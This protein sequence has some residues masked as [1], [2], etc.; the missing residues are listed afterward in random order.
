MDLKRTAGGAMG[1]AIVLGAGV[2]SAASLPMETPTLAA[3]SS[4]VGVCD[5]DGVIL[6]YDVAFDE[7]RGSYV[8]E[9]VAVGDIDDS[10]D[11]SLLSLVL[12][13]DGVSVSTGGPIA[14]PAGDGPLRVRV[15]PRP[16]AGSVDRIHLVIVG[17]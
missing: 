9:A 8:V 7:T 4:A 2:A 1:L 13:R 11:G 14:V 10:C 17:R 12:T 5:P 6:D 16:A 3:G 15:D